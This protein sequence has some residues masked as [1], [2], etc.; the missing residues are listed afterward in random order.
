[1]SSFTGGLEERRRSARSIKSIQLARVTRVDLIFR[2]SRSPTVEKTPCLS[3]QRERALSPLRATVF[4]TA[5]RGRFFCYQCG[6]MI[7]DRVFYAALALLLVGGVVAPA[8]V[9]LSD[10]GLRGAIWG[11]LALLS[12]DLL[13]ALF[14]V[15]L[16]DYAINS[17]E[18]EVDP[19]VEIAALAFGTIGP[20]GTHALWVVLRSGDAGLDVSDASIIGALMHAAFRNGAVSAY[21]SVLVTW[22]LLSFLLAFASAHDARNRHSDGGGPAYF[23]SMLLLVGG[24]LFLVPWIDGA[25]LPQHELVEIAGRQASFV[26][27]LSLAYAF[28]IHRVRIAQAAVRAA[29]Q[30]AKTII[31]VALSIA[32]A[33]AI[34]LIVVGLIG[35]CLWLAGLAGPLFAT[36]LVVGDV[37]L[38]ATVAA[39]VLFGLIAGVRWVV[40]KAQ[41]LHAPPRWVWIGAALALVLLPILLTR[42]GGAAGSE[43]DGPPAAASISIRAVDIACSGFRWEYGETDRITAPRWK[44]R[45]LP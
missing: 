24:S 7:G 43:G 18:S 33:L 26:V 10:L 6:G 3:L 25:A 8:G 27:L 4:R 20:L 28:V 40:A 34:V 13:L 32:A 31:P 1:M 21:F 37:V 5:F 39:V 12:F 35:V 42:N 45:R 23:F 30:S 14:A 41:S 2:P 36:L 11:W 9:M 22:G 17:K 19:R 29:Q 44:L 38:I 15:F 16:S